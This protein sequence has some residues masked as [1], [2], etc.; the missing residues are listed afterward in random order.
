[1]FILNFS[2]TC[3][4]RLVL[5]DTLKAFH[6]LK[7]KQKSVWNNVSW[8]I[9]VCIF[10]KRIQYTIHWDKTQMLKK[11]PSDKINGTKNAFF[12][13]SRAPTNHS[14]TFNI[15][16]L[17]ELQH[18]VRL[19]KNVYGIFQFWFCFV[20]INKMHGLFDFKTS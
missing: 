7:N 4:G 9:K 13:L 16:F 3:V 6:D 8:Y 5:K 17:H 15:R 19:S 20:F 2:V 11:L 1:M 18:K 12:F 14:F 10:W